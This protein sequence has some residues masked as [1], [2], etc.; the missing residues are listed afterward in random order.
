MGA[1]I[2]L[3]DSTGIIDMVIHPANGTIVYAAAW[4]RIRR[5]QYRQYGGETSDLS[6]HRWRRY[7]GRTNQWIAHK[8]FSERTNKLGYITEQSQCALCK[9]CRC[10]WEYSS[11]QNQ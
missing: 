7:L 3:S 10:Q 2:V 4:E 1:K 5:P 9:I 6:I 11:I 8:C